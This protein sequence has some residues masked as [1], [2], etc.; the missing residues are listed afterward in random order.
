[1]MMKLGEMMMLDEVITQDELDKAL[2]RQKVMGGRIGT[3]LLEL[4]YVTENQVVQ[5]L[6]RQ[7]NVPPMPP[8]VL[9]FVSDKVIATIP[10]QIAQDSKVIPFKRERN[11]L[12]VAMADPLDLAAIDALGFIAGSTIKIYITAEARIIY[13]LQ[14]Y[15]KVNPKFRYQQLIKKLDT[16]ADTQQRRVT[17]PRFTDSAKLAKEKPKKTTI[18]VLLNGE[19]RRKILGAMCEA[20]TP[21]CERV[22]IYIIDKH[23]IAFWDDVIEFNSEQKG[24]LLNLDLQEDSFLK[25]FIG[26]SEPFC[27]PIPPNERN[28]KLIGALGDLYPVN[29]VVMPLVLGK[30]S[31]GIVYCDNLLSSEPIKNF[32]AFKKIHLMALYSVKIYYLKKR[33]TELSES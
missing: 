22:L 1:M 19:S 7:R 5:Y 24:E 32:D 6:A 14:K 23:T 30:H 16:K 10:L 8:G 29:A 15:Y 18:E 21:L 4:G 13:S 12:H 31:Y 33:I 3:N 20:L 9:D 26:S 25:D 2:E 28:S 17:P 27:G 11:Q